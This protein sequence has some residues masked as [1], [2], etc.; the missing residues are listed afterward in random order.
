MSR[1]VNVLSI[2]AWACGEMDWT[3]NNWSKV[4]TCDLDTLPDTEGERIE[5]LISEGYLYDTPRARA[6]CEIED[7]QFNYVL[8][9]K[10]TREPL[11]A[12]AYGEIES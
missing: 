6:E 10:E 8:V 11:F 2:D 3:W 1:I 12:I 5:W 7:D 9:D 4:G